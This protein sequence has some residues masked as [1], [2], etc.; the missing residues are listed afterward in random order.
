MVSF[1]HKWIEFLLNK[2]KLSQHQFEF[3]LESVL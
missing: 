2:Y 1:V 3:E